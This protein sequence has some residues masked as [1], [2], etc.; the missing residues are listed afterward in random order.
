LLRTAADSLGLNPFHGAGWLGGYAS[1]IQSAIFKMIGKESFDAP[2][3]SESLRLMRT[4]FEI[5]WEDA[6]QPT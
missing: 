6:S 2:T 4:F 5:E 1:V 3:L